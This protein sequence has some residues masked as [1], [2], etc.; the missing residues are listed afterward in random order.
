[1]KDNEIIIMRGN[2]NDVQGLLDLCKEFP[3]NTI[4][5]EIGS[6]AGESTKIFLESGKVK[7]L[8]AIDP[9]E[10]GYDDTDA[11]SNSDF[12]LVENIFDKNVQG[13]N[14]IKLKM[15]MTEAFDKLPEV[16]VIYIDGDHHYDAVNN[17][18]VL[19]LR[20]IKSGGIICGHDYHSYGENIVKAVNNLFIQPDKIFQDS[21]W[22]VRINKTIDVRTQDE[23][24]GKGDELYLCV[25]MGFGDYVIAFSIIKEFAKRYNKIYLYAYDIYYENIKRLFN[26][27]KNV[28]VIIPQIIDNRFI[29]E[30]GT[31]ILGMENIIRARMKNPDIHLDEA[32][33][34]QVNMPLNKKWEDFYFERNIEN[35]K[36]VYYNKLGLKDNEEYI[37]IQDDKYRGMVVNDEYV[38]KNVKIINSF[39]D[40]SISLLDYLYTIEHAK[41]V[42]VINSGLIHFIDLMQIKHDNLY[43]HRYIKNHPNR[44][45]ENSQFSLKLNWKIV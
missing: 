44:S 12:K 17:D 38:S 32:Y 45:A 37:F 40:H 23:I 5:A 29:T 31:F 9:W 16:D 24:M 4:M 22:M 36:D 7:Q 33:Y 13:F 8:Y 41:E 27:I 43:Y 39:D 42:H 6:Y 1:M 34:N 21:S 35:E 2:P 26:S 25:G 14:V 19:S 11:T 18:I 3:E 28:E 30:N 15:T 20:K 10:T